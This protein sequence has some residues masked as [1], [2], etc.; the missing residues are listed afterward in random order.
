MNHYKIYSSTRIVILVIIL[1][2]ILVLPVMRNNIY[3]GRSEYQRVLLGLD[4]FSNFLKAD[5]DIS[6]KTDHGRLILVL[7]YRDKKKRAEKLA[8][9]L[10]Q[11]KTIKKIPVQIEVTN[12]IDL[13]K[14]KNKKIAGIFLTRKL[15]SELKSV[16]EYGRKNRI[17]VYSPFE[18]DVEKGVSGGL[19]ITHKILLYIN[20]NT[21]KSSGI[22]IKPFILR[23]VKQYK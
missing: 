16:T 1:V 2:I 8:L 10:K 12:D 18:G 6:E 11:V 20:M 5:L 21:I 15:G 23:K 17:I 4:M 3:A 14:Y 9:Y 13:K 22:R 19:I 7:M